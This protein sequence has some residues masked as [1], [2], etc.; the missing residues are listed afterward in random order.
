MIWV[1]SG[2]MTVRNCEEV[3]IRIYRYISTAYGAKRID[4]HGYRRLNRLIRIDMKKPNKTSLA[5]NMT[6][7]LAL[8]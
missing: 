8:E 2:V 4:M 3:N 6:V 5:N 1:K 7:K